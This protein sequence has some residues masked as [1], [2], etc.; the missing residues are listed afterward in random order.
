M[1]GGWSNVIEQGGGGKLQAGLSLLWEESTVFYFGKQHYPSIS[2][3]KL[4]NRTTMKCDT[5]WSDYLLF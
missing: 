2:T 3:T 4:S 1:D 5:S